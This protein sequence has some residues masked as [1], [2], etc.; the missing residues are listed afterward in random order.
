VLHKENQQ[1]KPDRT[2]DRTVTFGENK[3][4]ELPPQPKP[5]KTSQAPTAKPHRP[6]LYSLKFKQENRGFDEKMS[7]GNS[8]SRAAICQSGKNNHPTGAQ[9]KNHLRYPI[10]RNQR[11]QTRTASGH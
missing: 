6:P 8:L 3:V 9:Q 7:Y 11:Q 5:S 2:A 4:V 10:K 1:Q